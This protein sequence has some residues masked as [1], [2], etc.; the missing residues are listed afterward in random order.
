MTAANLARVAEPRRPDLETDVAPCRYLL[1]D[2]ATVA[3]RIDGDRV[4]SIEVADPRHRTVSGVG[5][6]SSRSE[7]RRTYG[8]HASLEEH[9]DGWRYVLRSRDGRRVLF[10]DLDGGSVT[11]LTVTTPPFARRARRCL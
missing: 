6:G 2:D 5:V 4:A 9:A 7:V 11:R 10:I 1:L 8:R 3:V